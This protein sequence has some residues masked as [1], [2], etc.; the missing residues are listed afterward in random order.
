MTYAARSAR[1]LGEFPLGAF[2]VGKKPGNRPWTWTGQQTPNKSKRSCF[3]K[4]SGN[5]T[6]TSILG[7][8]INESHP[9]PGTLDMRVDH[10]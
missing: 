10:S 6:R 5:P 7:L 2:L 9:C 1:R 3:G 4:G 8:T